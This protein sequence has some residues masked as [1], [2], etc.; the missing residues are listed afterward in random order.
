MRK[1][2]TPVPVVPLD[3]VKAVVAKP[4]PIGYGSVGSNGARSRRATVYKQGLAVLA[5][6]EKLPV[7]IKNL[8]ASGCRLEYFQKVRPEGR[9]L[10]TE[11]SIPLRQHG[12]VVW[13]ADGACGVQF[14]AEPD[15]S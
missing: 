8:S 5:H 3:R 11:P 13:H 6:G 12:D 7:V 1:D 4:A 14:V 2:T 10:I 9:V 15:A